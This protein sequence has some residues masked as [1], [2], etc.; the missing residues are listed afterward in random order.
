MVKTP[1]SCRLKEAQPSVLAPYCSPSAYSNEGHRVVAGQR[2]IQA[3][4]DIFLGW[5]EVETAYIFT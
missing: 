3:A 2:V 5:G 4:P 1:Y